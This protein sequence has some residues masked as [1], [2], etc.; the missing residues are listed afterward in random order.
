MSRGD[1]K[2]WLLA[3]DI[4]EPRRLRRVHR[5]VRRAGASVQYSAYSITASDAALDDVLLRLRGVIAVEADDV[6]AYHL[7]ARCRVWTL[8]RQC[9]PE[10]VD[11][12]ADTA[13]KLL[14]ETAEADQ[15]DA[16]DLI[17]WSEP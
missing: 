7:P 11:V 14:L 1:V 9:M 15:P 4:A 12:D 2:T 16:G 6:R 5:I 10:G 3:Y 8:G 13:A 17:E